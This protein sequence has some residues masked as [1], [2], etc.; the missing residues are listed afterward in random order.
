MNSINKWFPSFILLSLFFI[1][2]IVSGA[3]PAGKPAMPAGF[4]GFD[5][6]AFQ[7]QM[8]AEMHAFENLPSEEQQ[9][10]LETEF[11]QMMADPTFKETYDK[12]EQF[13]QTPEGQALF[14]KIEQDGD[15]SEEEFSQL[16]K[17]MD[18]TQEPETKEPE[19]KVEEKPKAEPEPVITSEDQK[20]I[21]M[22]SD[23]IANTASFINKSAQIIDLSSKV[24]RWE[25]KD[26]SFKWQ[27]TVTWNNFKADLEK[28]ISTLKSLLE[29]DP[30]TK[31][32]RHITNLTA[33]KALYNN[34]SKVHQVIAEF[35]P[36]IEDTTPEMKLSKK[37]KEPLKRVISEY[38]EALFT[39]KLPQE[40][41]KLIAKFDPTAKKIAEEE[42]KAIKKAEEESKKPRR[43]GRTITAGS[44]EP[45]GDYYPSYDMDGYD[46]GY[47]PT[48]YSPTSYA[49]SPYESPSLPEPT[50]PKKQGKPFAPG[51]SKA[52]DKDSEKEGAEDKKEK[53][54]AEKI[55]ERMQIK[56]SPEIDRLK[57]DISE[58]LGVVD[59]LIGSTPQLKNVK[60]YITGD[61]KVD[62]ELATQILP[63]INRELSAR[64]GALADISNLKRKVKHPKQR[65]KIK[66]ELKKS[67]D[68]QKNLESF[69]KQVGV[70]KTE[71]ETL[72]R[73]ISPEKQWAYFDMKS[74]AP[75]V[76][77]RAKETLEQT[78]E[79]ITQAK[80][81][82]EKAEK[83]EKPVTK[84]EEEEV[85]KRAQEVFGRFAGQPSEIEQQIPNPTSLF[86]VADLINQ[87][88]KAIE[89][90][91]K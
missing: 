56:E 78:K 71:F 82:V 25:K 59:N 75:A 4:P 8:E 28:L 49:P 91:V 40:L 83:E 39:L 58:K 66:E 27:K 7:K 46:P 86:E 77:E 51:A 65:Q 72:K 5:D 18:P 6:P 61:Q 13:S 3:M 67:F 24:I 30:K 85:L 16:L 23:L 33:D 79:T 41:D 37:S 44:P 10:L 52:K 1:A 89:V 14:E 54:E 32:Y 64:R 90:F 76:E 12:I 29:Q 63:D 81:M 36:Q 15:I 62:V 38:T 20:A 21:K 2:N 17:Y 42:E 53:S 47:S 19:T 35:E 88:K 87:L 11:E 68:K 43:P 69:T 55:L 57:R 26:P 84:E 22:I 45:V 34:L 50:V 48:P 70:L 60:S 31:S 80:K 74:K 9:K 73:S